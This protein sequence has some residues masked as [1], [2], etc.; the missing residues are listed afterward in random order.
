MSIIQHLPPDS[1]TRSND[2]LWTD[3]GDD[4][5]KDK[6]IFRTI[7]SQTSRLYCRTRIHQEMYIYQYPSFQF[8]TFDSSLPSIKES[9]TFCMVRDSTYIFIYATIVEDK[10][11]L[12]GHNYSLLSSWTICELI[13][14]PMY[15]FL[16]MG[17]VIC[18]SNSWLVCVHWNITEGQNS[19]STEIP[20]FRSVI[21]RAHLLA[22]SD[23]S[24][25]CF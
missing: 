12:K 18:T 8:W 1:Y 3:S 16:I 21:V 24:L 6:Y 15:K 22:S 4:W 14:V 17:Q 2:C 9:D 25:R 10:I 20:G 11:L 23:F 5:S 7:W 13:K 19:S